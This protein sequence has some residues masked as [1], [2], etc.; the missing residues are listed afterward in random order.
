MLRRR[1]WYQVDATAGVPQLVEALLQLLHLCRVRVSLVGLAPLRTREV[2]SSNPHAGFIFAVASLFAGKLFLVATLT[3][4]G[5]VD[6]SRVP[7]LR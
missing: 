4:Y 1:G 5:R 3:G 6:L 2:S 7:A